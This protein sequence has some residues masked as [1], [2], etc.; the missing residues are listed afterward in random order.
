MAFLRRLASDQDGVTV[1]EF[2]L[3]APVFLL[4][5]VGIFD[6]GHMVYI[7]SVLQGAMQDAGRDSSLESAST[8]R[9]TIDA[10][11]TSQ[12][13][14]VIPSAE[15]EF[16]RKNYRDFTKVGMPEDIVDKNNNNQYDED[17]CFYDTFDAGGNRNGLWDDDIGR[18]GVGGAN[19]VVLFTATTTYDRLFP[20]W[21]LIGVGQE[22]Q[23][24]ASTVLRNQPFATQSQRP[25]VL[26]CPDE[27]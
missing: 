4:L 17:E 14:A 23:I 1:V 15:L 12:V 27:D 20:L 18:D 8:A 9:A 19:D 5:L 22:V 2:A 21:R 10:Y 7:R 26:V 16:E 24:S 11:V 13:Q 3:V 6:I 25:T